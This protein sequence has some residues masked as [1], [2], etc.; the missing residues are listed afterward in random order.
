M[1]DV[2]LTTRFVFYEDEEHILRTDLILC[3]ILNVFL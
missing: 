3:T 1:V 2:A